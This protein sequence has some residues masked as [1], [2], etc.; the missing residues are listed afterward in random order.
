MVLFPDGHQLTKLVFESYNPKRKATAH[1]LLQPG[2][3]PL[4]A[5]MNWVLKDGLGQLGGVIYGRYV[6]W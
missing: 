6:W 5:A 3:V 1:L 2:S 4:A